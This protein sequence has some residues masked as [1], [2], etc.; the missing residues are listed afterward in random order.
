M[1]TKQKKTYQIVISILAVVL[2]IL[3][4]SFAYSFLRVTGWSF[5]GRFWVGLILMEVPF[6]VLLL[7]REL[8][9]K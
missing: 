1:R 6:V 7:V 5:A 3:T 8:F 9:R 2:T 4:S